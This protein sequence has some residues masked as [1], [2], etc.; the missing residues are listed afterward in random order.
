[1]SSTWC[2]VAR[3][4]KVNP[5][6][7]SL[8]KNANSRPILPE[9]FAIDFVL[10]DPIMKILEL[11]LSIVILSC[12]FWDNL[13]FWIESAAA[14]RSLI[15]NDSDL[16]FC[17][18]STGSLWAARDRSCRLSAPGRLRRSLDRSNILQDACSVFWGHHRRR[19]VL[20]SPLRSCRCVNHIS[21]R[22]RS[23]LICV[24]FPGSPEFRATVSTFL[25]SCFAHIHRKW[26]HV[27]P[28]LLRKKQRSYNK[29]CF[30]STHSFKNKPYSKYKKLFKF[31]S[32]VTFC[33]E[34]EKKFH[35]VMFPCF[36]F[37][38]F[39][40]NMILEIPSS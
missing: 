19:K 22:T 15:K 4:W 26:P 2:A 6:E 34:I 1:M 24:P 33:A 31:A 25:P 9:K 29:L 16:I 32:V 40:S 14:C 27:F 12:I 28:T 21:K 20:W 17:R 30:N 13:V 11:I 18:W 8:R 38:T 5:T 3:L 36:C 39:L 37:F 7:K 35:K 23:P 10:P